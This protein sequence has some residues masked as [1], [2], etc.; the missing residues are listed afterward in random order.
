MLY[1]LYLF[2]LVLNTAKPQ[3]LQQPKTAKNL[4]IFETAKPHTKSAQTIKPTSEKTFK[5]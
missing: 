4:A 5:L 3:K 2:Y 1:I